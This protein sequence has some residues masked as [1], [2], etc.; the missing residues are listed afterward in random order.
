L[1]ERRR[2]L[3]ENHTHPTLTTAIETTRIRIAC[4]ISDA[5]SE[6]YDNGLPGSETEAKSHPILRHRQG[7]VKVASWGFETS[8]APAIYR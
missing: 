3:L 4:F 2:F 1:L 6:Q 5:F 8:G 7:V